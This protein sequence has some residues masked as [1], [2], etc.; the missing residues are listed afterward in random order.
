MIVEVLRLEQLIHSYGSLL[1]F[2]GDAIHQG[3][4]KDPDGAVCLRKQKLE[5]SKAIRAARNKV[6]PTRPRDP[7]P[8]AVL[9]LL[10]GFLP[11]FAACHLLVVTTTTP[12]FLALITASYAR[13]IHDSRAR[14]DSDRARFF[15]AFE[16]KADDPASRAFWVSNDNHHHDGRLSVRNGQRLH[17][18]LA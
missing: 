4:S 7:A 10:V 17:Q 5:E 13:S 9:A 1:T 14:P 16:K 3:H 2:N 8:P 18:L 6:R 11:C 15:K 12:L